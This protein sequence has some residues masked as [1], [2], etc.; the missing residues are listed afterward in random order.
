[1][2]TM[3]MSAQFI[4]LLRSFRDVIANRRR[5]AATGKTQPFHLR[6]CKDHYGPQAVKFKLGCWSV[7]LD[8]IS[9]GVS[10][11]KEVR[12]TELHFLGDLNTSGFELVFH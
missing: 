11:E 4:E 3:I 8:D 1:M 12:V 7:K 6:K 9:V 2:T 5:A 10:D